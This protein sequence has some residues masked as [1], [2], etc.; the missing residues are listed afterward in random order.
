MKAK[1]WRL[2]I[3]HDE[4]YIVFEKGEPNFKVVNLVSML[5]QQTKRLEEKK[6]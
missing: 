5:R 2:A 1:D 4:Q 6:S 3:L